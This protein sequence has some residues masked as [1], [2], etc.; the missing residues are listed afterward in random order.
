MSK[1]QQENLTKAQIEQRLKEKSQAIS[2]RFESLESKVPGKMPVLLSVVK[3]GAK[4]KVAMAVGAGL[5]VGFI[6]FRKKSSSNAI[7]YDDGV[8]Q[9]S[10]Q[11]ASRVAELLRKGSNSEEAIHTAFQEQPP[12]MRLSSETEGVLATVLKQVMQAGVTMAGTELADY[13][14]NR[15][16]EKPS[17]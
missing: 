12:L 14:R 1:V 11:L 7:E 4:S 16:K 8:H 10:N 3:Q 5:L 13:L 9:L 17:S 2:G 15:L 6:F